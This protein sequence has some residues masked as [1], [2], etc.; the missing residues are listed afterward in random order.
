MTNLALYGREWSCIQGLGPTLTLKSSPTAGLAWWVGQ[1][2]LLAMLLSR[3]KDF[4]AIHLRLTIWTECILLIVA[5]VL[6]IYNFEFVGEWLILRSTSS[7]LLVEVVYARSAYRSSMSLA[8]WDVREAFGFDGRQRNAHACIHHEVFL[9]GGRV[10]ELHGYCAWPRLVAISHIASKLKKSGCS[11]ETFGIIFFSGKLKLRGVFQMGVLAACLVDSQLDSTSCGVVWFGCRLSTRHQPCTSSITQSSSAF[12]YV[13]RPCWP[14]MSQI[15]MLYY[16]LYG[17]LR[18]LHLSS[19]GSSHPIILIESVLCSLLQQSLQQA[20]Y[21]SG[22]TTTL[23]SS[24][25][26]SAK[27]MGRRKY[28]EN[29]PT[30]YTTVTNSLIG[31]DVDTP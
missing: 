15:Y 13:Y 5:R 31:A 20:Y 23:T 17:Q 24:V 26:S 14:V 27:L 18:Q 28:G 10:L 4:L 1:F 2:W 19:Q 9:V 30:R 8:G 29:I 11:C 6:Q 25:N 12:L 22:S 3:Y 16:R 7:V 21:V